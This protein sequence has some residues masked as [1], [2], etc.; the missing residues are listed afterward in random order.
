MVL[1][2]ALKTT[3]STGTGFVARISHP[4]CRHLDIRDMICCGFCCSSVALRNS[5]AHTS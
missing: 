5:A 1:R 3:C 2:R 4:D